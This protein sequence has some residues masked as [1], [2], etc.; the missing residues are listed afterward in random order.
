MRLVISNYRGHPQTQAN[1]V[2]VNVE[3]GNPAE[4]IGKKVVWSAQSGKEFVGN[5][6]H[7]HG[8]HAVRARFT[9]GLPGQAL[10]TEVQL[11]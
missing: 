1:Q 11:R 8:K 10:G 6:T 5:I 7:T 3:G 4:L 9:Q 2:I